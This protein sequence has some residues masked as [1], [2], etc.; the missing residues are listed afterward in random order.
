MIIDED[1][2]LEHFGVR[3]MKWG[4]RRD[5]ATGVSKRTDREARKDAEES[6]RAKMFYGKGAGTRRKLINKSVEDKKKRDPEY[7]R[8]FD[9]HLGRQDM[10]TH[11][12]GARRERSRTDRREATRQTAGYFARRA[13]GE[14]GTRAAFAAAGV[15]GVAFIRSD[16]GQQMASQAMRT[17]RTTAARARSSQ[18]ARQVDDIFR[19]MGFGS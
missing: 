6:A 2:D 16:R 10:S 15:A 12:S 14:M 18:G 3:G 17:L 8:A 5:R 13:T 4:V 1:A 11:A 7:A 19:S 9:H